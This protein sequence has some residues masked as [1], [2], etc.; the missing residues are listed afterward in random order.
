MSAP[1]AAR[2]APRV[3]KIEPFMYRVNPERDYSEDEKKRLLHVPDWYIPVQQIARFA[4]AIA[5]SKVF[6]RPLRNILLRG[7]AGCGKTEGARAIASMTGSPYG[8]VTGHAEMEFFDC[9]TRF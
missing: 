2:R 8:V 4:E 7:P 3:D 1:L 9:V 5:D 6:E